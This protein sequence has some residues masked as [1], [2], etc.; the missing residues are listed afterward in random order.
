MKKIDLYPLF[1]DSYADRHLCGLCL[2]TQTGK[3]G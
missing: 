3:Y 2:D 1:C